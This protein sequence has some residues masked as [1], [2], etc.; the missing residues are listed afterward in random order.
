M[1]DSFKNKMRN[2]LVLKK[3]YR[4]LRYFYLAIKDFFQLTY[5]NIFKKEFLFS[6][7][8][9]VNNFGDKFN[10]DLLSFFGKSLIYVNNY[11]K[12][13]VALTGSILHMYERDFSGYVLGSG[14][15]KVTNFRPK[16]NWEIVMLRGPLTAEQC[17]CRKS[18]LYGD[19]GIL[20]S[21]IYPKVI[22]KKYSLGIIPHDI[23]LDYARSLNLD[24]SIKIISP[25]QSPREVAKQI[26]ECQ[27][28]AS[29][30]LHGLVFADSFIIPNIHIKFGNKLIGGNH[31]FKD[32]YLGMNSQ[33]EFVNY[34]SS[35]TKE[36][37]ISK[38]KI[39]FDLD[40]IQEKQ[41]E[42]VKVYDNTIHKVL[43]ERR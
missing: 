11:K 16:V 31:K 7:Y 24:S 27:N 14:F 28:I 43:A 20:A 4:K 39:R 30:S 8:A 42:I 21:L 23:D 13:E 26:K 12:S 33:Y 41:R 1:I 36:D 29:S 35:L 5:C 25:R 18:I 32:Y 2:I 22:K 15:I 9:R 17:G 40:F 19:P 34:N 10:K 6:H 3:C 37:I 38:C